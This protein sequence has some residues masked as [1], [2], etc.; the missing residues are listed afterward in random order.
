MRSA[1][2]IPVALMI[3]LGF[4]LLLFPNVGP[5]SQDA[6]ASDPSLV[7]NAVE[8]ADPRLPESGEQRSLHTILVL[9]TTE[10]GS[11]SASHSFASVPAGSAPSDDTLIELA[12]SSAVIDGGG[13]SVEGA[14]ITIT[15]AGLGAPLADAFLA[16]RSTGLID[17]ATSIRDWIACTDGIAPDSSQRARDDGLYEIYRATYEALHPIHA[18]LANT[19]SF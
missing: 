7:E 11:A 15:V 19:E 18:R 13:A 2:W 3:A 10:T 17:P 12:G 9:D 5:S 1:K 8:Q 6:T 14:V 4:S 16:G